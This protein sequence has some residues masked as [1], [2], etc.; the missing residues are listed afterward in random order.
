MLLLTEILM[1]NHLI[2]GFLGPGLI[3]DDRY[4]VEDS[5]LDTLGMGG[6]IHKVLREE[7][8]CIC[9]NILQPDGL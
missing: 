1:Q 2:F 6:R 7:N 3:D 5:G 4:A 9:A 8:P